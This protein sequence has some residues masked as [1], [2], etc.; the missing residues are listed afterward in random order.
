MLCQ[1]IINIRKKV[2]NYIRKCRNQKEYYYYIE[3]VSH[4]TTN[5]FKNVNN[6]SYF[7]E[8]KHAKSAEPQRARQIFNS[9]ITKIK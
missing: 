9:K 4:E 2:T 3:N 7:S 6:F 1:N 8:G 5:Y